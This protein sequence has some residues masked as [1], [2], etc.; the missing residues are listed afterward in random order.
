MVSKLPEFF[1]YAPDIRDDSKQKDVLSE[2]R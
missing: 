2:V 1:G